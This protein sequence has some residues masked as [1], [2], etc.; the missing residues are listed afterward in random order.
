MRSL[1]DL[2]RSPEGRALLTSKGVFTDPAAFLGQLRPACKPDLATHLGL[3]EATIIW[4]GQ[5]LY[6]DYRQSVLCK[7][8]CLQEI[9]QAPGLSPLFVWADTDRSGSDT[10][11]TKFAWPGAAQGRI[12]IAPPRTD[13]SETRFVALE[14]RVLR[15]AID[16]LG[17]HLSQSGGW[18]RESRDKLR[19]LR[20]LF[21]DSEP[22]TLGA[23]N[24]RLTECLLA[25][26]LGFMPPSVVLSELLREGLFVAEIDLVLDCLPDVIRVFNQAVQALIQEEIDPQVRPL[27]EDYLPLFFSCKHDNRRLRLHHQVAG[28]EH[29]A[30]GTCKCGRAYA[31]HLGRGR[32]SLAE[33]ARTRRWSPDVTLPLL[34][35]GYV[36]GLVAGKSSALYGLVLN[37]VLTRVWGRRPVPMLVPER[38]EA[39]AN[40]P[41]QVDS[42]LYTYLAG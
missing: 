24:L 11:I 17:A 23:F 18:S 42:L 30:V 39:L 19:R 7:I 33:I 22:G 36:S 38:F 21:L 14:P 9:A 1:V 32:L 35:N 2:L 37:E 31:F 27:P 10:L 20:A 26:V 28:G 15:S 16:R 5:Q 8:L 13:E 6:V 25:A 40:A 12:S 29:R 41:A 3:G 34:L 4:S